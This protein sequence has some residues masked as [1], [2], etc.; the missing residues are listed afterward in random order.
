MT[1]ERF[2]SNLIVA[3]P[4]ARQSMLYEENLE[5]DA[6]I[7]K[8]APDKFKFSAP[9]RSSPAL[10]L[11]RCLGVGRHRIFKL[12]RDDRVPIDDSGTI[13]RGSTKAHL[14]GISAFSSRSTETYPRSHL[15]LYDYVG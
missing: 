7:S 15:L 1:D 11:S 2:P 13:T 5:F 9:S 8:L 10:G 14:R 6:P 12:V 3:G 4:P